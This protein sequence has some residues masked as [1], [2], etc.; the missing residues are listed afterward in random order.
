MKKLVTS[1]FLSIFCLFTIF[2]TNANATTTTNYDKLSD[3]FPSFKED[4]AKY[5]T[6]KLISSDDVYV[7]FQLKDEYKNYEGTLSEGQFNVESFT[8]ED[9]EKERLN[10]AIN[11]IKSTR[12]AVTIGPVDTSQEPSWLRITFDVYEG[13]TVNKFR[14]YSF[15]SWKTR[16][17]F[18][19]TDGHGIST[20]D[21]MFINDEPF[22]TQYMYMDS[23]NNVTY[24]R[25][26]YIENRYGV[27]AKID[28]RGDTELQT[29][30]SHNSMIGVTAQ[31]SNETPGVKQSGKVY[32][33]YLHKEVALGGIGIAADGTPDIGLSVSSDSYSVSRQVSNYI[34]K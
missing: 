6:G 29:F 16:P 1:I 34:V 9:Y 5:S 7:R 30:V 18:T 3:L 20:S 15:A 11:T 22:E 24:T 23:Y 8:K 28:L 31:F 33:E 19:F 14:C 26:S 2:S 27:V 32:S 4:L 21:T 13:N 10:E 17:A 12:G 25:P